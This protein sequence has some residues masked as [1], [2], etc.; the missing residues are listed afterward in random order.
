MLVA[1][2]ARIQTVA[3]CAKQVEQVARFAR[4][5]LNFGQ[6]SY[7]DM[8]GETPIPHFSRSLQ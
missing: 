3:T 8:T 2:S 4:M 7:E 5:H 1:V 6:F